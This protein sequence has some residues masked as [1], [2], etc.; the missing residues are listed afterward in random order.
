MLFCP[1]YT[2]TVVPYMYIHVHV[3]V[4][5]C[6]HVKPNINNSKIADKNFKYVVYMHDLGHTIDN[7]IKFL[8]YIRLL[9]PPKSPI[10]AISWCASLLVVLV[11]VH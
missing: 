10:L 11:L 5:S 7:R 1:S 6:I 2:D 3:F 8:Y 4:Y 9:L